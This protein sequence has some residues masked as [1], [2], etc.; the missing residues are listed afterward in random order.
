MNGLSITQEEHRQEIEDLKNA[1][2]SQNHNEKLLY[3]DLEDARKEI[4]KLNQEI[5]QNSLD[6]Q[7]A[8]TSAKRGSNKLESDKEERTENDSLV[9]DHSHQNFLFGLESENCH[10]TPTNPGPLSHSN[11]EK[12]SSK[13]HYENTNEL[14]GLENTRN[15]LQEQITTAKKSNQDKMEMLLRDRTELKQPEKYKDFDY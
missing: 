4:E 6:N 7:T 5:N 8:E 15:E 1:L 13:I 11:L 9:W 2:N 10:S 12:D 3:N 14:T